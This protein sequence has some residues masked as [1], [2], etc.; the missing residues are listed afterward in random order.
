MICVYQTTDT[1]NSL[2][3]YI[4]TDDEHQ[5]PNIFTIICTSEQQ[6]KVII[7]KKWLQLYQYFIIFCFLIT[8]ISKRPN[9]PYEIKTKS[10]LKYFYK[11]LK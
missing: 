5:Y 9:S 3:Q 8:Y 11:G 4:T 6:Y 1:I 7:L 2:N 10:N